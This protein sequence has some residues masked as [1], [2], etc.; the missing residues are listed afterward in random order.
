MD[1]TDP[2]IRLTPLS[3]FATIRLRKHSR[4][5]YKKHGMDIDVFTCDNCGLVRK[6]RLAFDGYNT[7]GDCLYDK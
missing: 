2:D 5:A 4:E 1:P 6:C 7:N 3:L